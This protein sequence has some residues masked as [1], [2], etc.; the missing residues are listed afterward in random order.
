MV[1]SLSVPF[2]LSSLWRTGHVGRQDR[3]VAIVCGGGGDGA[4][5]ARIGW[6]GAGVITSRRGRIRGP[7]PLRVAVGEEEVIARRVAYGVSPPIDRSAECLAGID[8]VKLAVY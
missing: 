8:K 3:P 4:R 5:I 7:C 1:E 6:Y 2:S